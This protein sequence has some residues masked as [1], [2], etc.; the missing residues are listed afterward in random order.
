M[1][2]RLS[3]VPTL[4]ATIAVASALSGCGAMDRLANIGKAPELSKI[5]DPTR[6]AG[7]QPVSLPMPAPVVATRQANSLW[8]EGSRAFFKDQRAS[9]VGDIITVVISIDDSAAVDNE[10]TRTR[11]NSDTAA[12]NG[13]FGFENNLAD[14]LPEGVTGSNLVDLGSTT[15]N[16]G[17]GKVD[18]TEA[19]SLRIAGVVTQKLPNGNMVVYGRQEVRV[20]FEV[21]EVVVGGVIRAADITSSNTISYDQ[22]AEARISYGG[23]GQLTDVQQP[24]YGSQVLDVI[25]PF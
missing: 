21:R 20:N 15:S 19:I 13:L 6:A 10:T 24:R 18:R 12:L 3:S 25:M 8:Q 2:A 11:T 4:V 9:D 14:V 23:H 17:T 5:E 16:V 1:T 22:M 7:Y